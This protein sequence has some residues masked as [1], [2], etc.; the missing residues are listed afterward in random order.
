MP[1]GTPWSKRMRISQTICANRNRRRV[2]AAG[3][4]FEHGLNLLPRYMK[5][6]DDFLYTRTRLKIFKNRS[7]GHPG[8]AKHPCAAASVRH[9][10]DGGALGPIESRHS[11][12]SF[13][14]NVRQ[15]ARLSALLP[16]RFQV[17]LGHSLVLVP[18]LIPLVCGGIVR[19]YGS[20]SA[21]SHALNLTASPFF[22]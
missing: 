8:I 22:P 6:L 21:S 14:N 9:A 13:Q 7:D 11:R 16:K 10:F 4:K 2:E 18:A 3:G 5:L 17:L 20:F 15:T 1:L 19:R 12:A